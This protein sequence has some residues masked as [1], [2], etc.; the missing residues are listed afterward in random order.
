MFYKITHHIQKRRPTSSH[1]FNCFWSQIRS[2]LK[3]WK[4]AESRQLAMIHPLKADIRWKHWER[5]RWTNSGPELSGLVMQMMGFPLGNDTVLRVFREK[6]GR[7]RKHVKRIM[8]LKISYKNKQ[9]YR[10][11]S[12]VTPAYVAPQPEPQCQL[13]STRLRNRSQ[14]QTPG[15]EAVTPRTPHPQ[16][17]PGKPWPGRML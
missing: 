6:D 10:F 16:R 5:V 15:N 3:K 4:E 13:E 14:P 8:Q 7:G 12:S 11:I 9:N 1:S 17:G 2:F